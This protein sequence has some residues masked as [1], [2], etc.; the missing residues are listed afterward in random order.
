MNEIQGTRDKGGF[1]C[2]MERSACLSSRSYFLPSCVYATGYVMEI[3]RLEIG[4]ILGTLPFRLLT[5]TVIYADEEDFKDK[6]ASRILYRASF[7][8]LSKG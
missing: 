2:C 1:L 7:Y 3:F 6:N 5:S 8:S 4:Y